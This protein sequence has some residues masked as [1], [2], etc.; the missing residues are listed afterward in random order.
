MIIRLFNPCGDDPLGPFG[1]EIRRY[2]PD[3]DPYDP[4][5]DWD[6]GAHEQDWYGPFDKAA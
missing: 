3:P 4:D 5:E 2:V 6:A 1:D